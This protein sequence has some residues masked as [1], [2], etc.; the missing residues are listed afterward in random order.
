LV[1]IIGLYPVSKWSIIGLLIRKI[2]T[3]QNGTCNNNSS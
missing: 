2:G 3:D 1:K